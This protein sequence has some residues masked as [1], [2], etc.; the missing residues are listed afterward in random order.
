MTHKIKIDIVSDIVCPWCVI[1]Y[2]R[3]THAI[4]ELA[5][6]EHVKIEW[7]PFE[8]NPTMPVDGEDLVAHIARK[9]GSTPT[10]SAESRRNI[11]SLGAEVGFSFDFFEGMH[12]VNTHD[13]HILLQYAK[14]CGQ[15]TALTS[16]LFQAYFTHHQDIS[17][18]AI[19][20]EI[21]EK[22]G[23]NVEE[24][25]A[26]LTNPTTRQYVCTQQAY[27]QGL[28]VASV[29]TMLFNQGRAL[30]GAQDVGTYKNILSELNR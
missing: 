28:G 23:L 4:Q 9:Y 16:N 11:T 14:T 19:L 30:I 26:E 8:L 20:I 18:R 29:P 22:T 1:G 10:Q 5:L 13:A 3:L 25:F 6:E 15:Q 12:I 7:Q 21:L 2:Q 17:K 27:W 24:A